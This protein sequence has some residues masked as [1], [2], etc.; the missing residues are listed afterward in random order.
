MMTC[1][2]LHVSDHAFNDV[3]NYFRGL[4]QLELASGYTGT[5]LNNV[6]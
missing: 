3:W 2:K 1:F 6:K 5:Y 4:S